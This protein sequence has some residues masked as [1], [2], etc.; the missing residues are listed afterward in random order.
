MRIS[1]SGIELIRRFEGLR[2]EAYR[3]PVGIWTIGYG[4]TPASP[5]QI[6]SLVQA[7]DLLTHDVARFEEAVNDLVSVPLTQGQFDALVS[8]AYNLGE[9][10]LRDSTLLR[11]LNAGDRTAPSEFGRW[12]HADGKVLPG[13]VRR[14]AAEA[15]MFA[16]GPLPAPSTA[17]PPAAGETAMLPFIAAALPAL[18]NAAPSLIRLFGHGEQAEKNAAAAEKV[19]DVAKAIT[20]TD[21]IEGAVNQIKA[22][23]EIAAAF[24]REIETQWFSLAEAG[25]GGIAG[26]RDF[27]IAAAA[28]E[29]PFWRMPAFAITCALL[30]LIYLVV[31]AVLFAD[32]WTAEI[33]ASVVSAIVSGV[34][35]SVVGFWL[36]TSA[37]SQRKTDLLAKRATQE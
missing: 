16:S 22:S 13:L 2:L 27:N 9:A 24:A 20:G 30:P 17:A 23:P 37:G 4:H 32:G 18:I 26:A 14:R 8:F 33:R 15:Q 10:R 28:A 1:S 6:I 11:K 21:T 31:G 3:D 7:D 19:A 29:A 12:V 34:M 36:G 25:G 35:F 5:G